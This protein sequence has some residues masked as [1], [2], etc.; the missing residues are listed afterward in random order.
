MA[1]AINVTIPAANADL[2][3]APVRSNFATAAAEITALQNG[4]FAGTVVVGVP[5]PSP[6][7]LPAT[8]VAD[9]L[10]VRGVGANT[11]SRLGLNEAI[12]ASNV[13]HYVSSGAAAVIA[14]ERDPGTG[15]AFLQ[16]NVAEPGTAG[17][18]VTQEPV[19]S[20][21]ADYIS[22]EDIDV[23]V[24]PRH[25][26]L[27]TGELTVRGDPTSP[28][29]ERTSRFGMNLYQDNTPGVAWHYLA[30]GPGVI[31]TAREAPVG[32]FTPGGPT[33]VQI[34]V[35]DVGTA[36]GTFVNPAVAFAAYGA[37]GTGNGQTSMV[38]L[39]NTG[40]GPDNVQVLV[41]PANSGPGGNGRALYVPN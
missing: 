10:V 37:A 11:V 8:I 5:A 16:F 33:N 35:A 14:A 19:L 2:L 39:V 1:S 17:A 27:I 24:P 40:A 9:Q 25:G 13:W 41:G 34:L 7:P 26:T 21:F 20:L 12:D 22:V 15:K 23:P 29:A 38:P 6:A 28:G 3:S 32:S 36:G 4:Q 31:I 18:V 30:D